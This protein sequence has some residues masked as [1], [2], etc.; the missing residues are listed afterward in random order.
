MGDIQDVK[1]FDTQL[2]IV[3]ADVV[4]V[5][6]WTFCN[7]IYSLNISNANVI[8]PVMYG[9]Y[10]IALIGHSNVCLFRNDGQNTLVK[11]I[12]IGTYSDM[13]L[14]LDKFYLLNIEFGRVDILENLEGR[15]VSWRLSPVSIKLSATESKFSNNRDQICVSNTRIFTTSHMGFV[16]NIHDMQGLL[17]RRVENFFCPVRLFGVDLRENVLTSLVAKDRLE[18]YNKF[19]NIELMVNG[20][21]NSITKKTK[22]TTI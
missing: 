17:I 13:T 9:L 5:H 21:W 2:W 11:T 12:C 10:V 8:Y 15:E 18:V 3:H 20:L 1:R 16:L 14:H 6:T 19:G 4:T 22:T 7:Y